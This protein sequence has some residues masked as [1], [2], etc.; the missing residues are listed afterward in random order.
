[1]A[2][3]CY[4]ASRRRN[5]S[6][7]SSTLHVQ[8][9]DVDC[10]ALSLAPEDGEFIL[11][12]GARPT[13]DAVFT[14]ANDDAISASDAEGAQLRMVWGSARRSDR[15]ALSGSRTTVFMHGP[16]IDLDVKLYVCD[17]AGDGLKD[18]FPV[19]TLLSV[20]QSPGGKTL[21]NVDDT[22][23]TRFLLC[24]A[25]ATG[26]VVGYVR[27]SASGDAADDKAIKIHLYGTPRY[28]GSSD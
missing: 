1:M 3:D 18:S 15:A 5:V 16:G 24:K 19:G 6:P 4:G 21:P 11:M 9:R 10:S 26:W 23:G 27:E 20:V 14:G 7:K 13:T 17:D 22:A 25:G 12:S 28:H 8:T 2:L